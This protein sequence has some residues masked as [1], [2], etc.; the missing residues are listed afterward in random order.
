MNF[1]KDDKNLRNIAE[2]V[3]KSYPNLENLKAYKDH[4]RIGYQW[5]NKEK[6]HKGNITYGD[7]TLVSEKLKEFIDYD[8]IIT[9]YVNAHNISPKAQEML[10]Y[11][12]LRHIGIDKKDIGDF[13]FYLEP[14]TLEDFKDIVEKHGMDWITTL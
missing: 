12:E 11:H 14:H 1:T 7:C 2:K 3:I 6:K 9:F 5:S 10:M 13:K 4:V 8:F